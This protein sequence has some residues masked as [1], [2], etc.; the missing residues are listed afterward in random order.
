MH[1]E[2]GVAVQNGSLNLFRKDTRLAHFQN[3]ITLIAITARGNLDDLD[4][5]AKRAQLIGDPIRLPQCQLTTS[6][7][8]A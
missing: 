5:C 6:R 4:R 8:D 2:I 7:A 3:G 1:R